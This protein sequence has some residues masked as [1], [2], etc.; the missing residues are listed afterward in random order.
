MKFKDYYLREGN[1]L[2]ISVS[3]IIKFFK[4]NPYPSDDQLH[5]FADANDMEPDNLE[6]EVYAIISTFLTGGYAKEKNFTINDADPKE[7][8]KGIKVE[9][10]HLDSKSKYAKVLSTQIALDHL[11]EMDN[12]YSELEKMESK[13]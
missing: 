8:A 13:E 5:E 2:P 4:E 9:M 3:K 1:K 7:L 6:Q 11:A 10:E 12:Y